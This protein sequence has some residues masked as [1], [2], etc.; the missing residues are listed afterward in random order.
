MLRNSPARS[1]LA[2]GGADESVIGARP[3]HAAGLPERNSSTSGWLGWALANGWGGRDLA[4]DV[5]DAGLAAVFGSLL[6]ANNTS[7]G[8]SPDNVPSNDKVFRTTFPYLA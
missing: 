5:V 6:N 3:R 8:L 4:D 1:W 7:A 2:A